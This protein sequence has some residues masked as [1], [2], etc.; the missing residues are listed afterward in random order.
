M[1]RILMILLP[2]V[3]IGVGGFAAIT[4]VKN[5]PK[6]ETKTVRFPFR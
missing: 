6:P 1:R 4:M 3:V 5:R 2:L